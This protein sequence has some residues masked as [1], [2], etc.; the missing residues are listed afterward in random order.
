MK[1]NG[2]EL[3]QE[4]IRVEMLAY[5]HVRSDAEIRAETRKQEMRNLSVLLKS[6]QDGRLLVETLRDLFYDGD[7]L[8]DTP[9]KT[10]FNLGQ[11]NVV[12]FLLDL[13]KET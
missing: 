1:A 11:R 12:A 13:Q 5:G 10:Y 9:E 6:H 4:D 2:R 3:S 8:G 7:M